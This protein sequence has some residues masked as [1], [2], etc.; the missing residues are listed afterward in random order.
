[1]STP[2]PWPRAPSVPQVSTRPFSLVLRVLPV[3]AREGR[4]AGR[5]EVVDTGEIFAIKSTSDLVDL[6]QRLSLDLDGEA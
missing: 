4:L 6:V 2:P 3:A 5:V 1:M